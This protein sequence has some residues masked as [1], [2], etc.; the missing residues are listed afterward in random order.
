MAEPWGADAEL[1][2]RRL[3]Y[4]EAVAALEAAGTRAQDFRIP[5]RNAPQAY[6]DLIDADQRAERLRRS[7]NYAVDKHPAHQFRQILA[8]ADG[9]TAPQLS[10]WQWFAQNPGFFTATP[11]TDEERDDDARAAYILKRVHEASNA[12]PAYDPFSWGNYQ[13]ALSEVLGQAQV[14]AADLYGVP[15]TELTGNPTLR[16]NLESP[17]KHRKGFRD[18]AGNLLPW[19]DKESGHYPLLGEAA[20]T[21]AQAYFLGKFP[22]AALGFNAMGSGHNTAI[23]VAQQLSRGE[24]GGAIDALASG[25]LS[26][27]NPDYAAG[28]RDGPY[29]WRPGSPAEFVH[30]ADTLADILPWVVATPRMRRRAPAAGAEGRVRSLLGDDL[31]AWQRQHRDAYHAAAKRHHP[32]YGGSGE[33]QR[34]LNEA[35]RTG[36]TEALLRYA[37]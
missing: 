21:G 2:E 32:D 7:Y 13:G 34:A 1:A 37:R 27:L 14:E 3:A 10:R 25:P 29:D 23:P 18:E 33:A 9:V 26:L 36:D 4:E 16:G 22:A 19:Y 12:A 11:K 28:R 35:W 31:S 24:L 15:G 6:A 20:G 5:H 8:D 30:A 17:Y